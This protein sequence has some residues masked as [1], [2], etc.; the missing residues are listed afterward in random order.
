MCCILTITSTSIVTDIIKSKLETAKV[1][2][3][4]VVIDGTMQN[5]KEVGKQQRIIMLLCMYNVYIVMKETNGDGV[6]R[7]VDASGVAS[8]VNNCFTMLR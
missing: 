4:D 5:L 7:I 6:G 2:G 3:A 8:V 1:M